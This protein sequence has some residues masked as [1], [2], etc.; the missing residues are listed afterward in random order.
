MTN[1]ILIFPL[2]IVVYPDENINLHIFEPKYKQL[3][4]D[5]FSKNKPFGISAV[6]E[7]K[8]ADLGTLIEIKEIVK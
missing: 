7:N 3:V 2:N 8:I 4:N 1:F 5:C 6:I